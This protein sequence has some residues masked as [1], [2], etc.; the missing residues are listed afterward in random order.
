MI[1]STGLTNIA[2]ISPDGFGG[3]T[4]DTQALP[5]G[6]ASFS[7]S[8]SPVAATPEPSTWGLMILGFLATALQLKHMRRKGLLAGPPLPGLTPHPAPA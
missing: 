4:S 6:N 7:F 8:F 1:A 2:F 5:N 3:F